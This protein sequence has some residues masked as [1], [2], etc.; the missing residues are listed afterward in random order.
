MPVAVDP[1]QTKTRWDSRPR[2]VRKKPQPIV[3]DDEA[4]ARL[5]MSE[6]EYRREL[7]RSFVKFA[8]EC[9]AWVVSPPF[10][11]RCRVLVPDGSTILERLSQLP[12][13]P[14]ARSGAISQF[15]HGGRMVPVTEIF[16][17]LWPRD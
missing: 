11:R 4:E 3:L 2:I 8:R 6:A 17:Q 9:N 14:V 12:K 15:L 13:Y 5:R 16:V 10:E 1:K 7:F